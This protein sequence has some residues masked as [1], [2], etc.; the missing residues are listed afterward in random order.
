MGERMGRVTIILYSIIELMP[1]FLFARSSF[2][3]AVLVS[4]VTNLCSPDLADIS[5]R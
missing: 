5:R 4:E 1:L 3:P 2:A